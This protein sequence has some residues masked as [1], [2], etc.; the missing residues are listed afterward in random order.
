MICSFTR[1]PIQYALETDWLVGA[2]GFETLHQ[3]LCAIGP[4]VIVRRK[5]W[6]QI[7]APDSQQAHARSSLS[8]A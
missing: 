6:Q 7:G 5:E 1:G 8:G 2:G 3:K 4:T